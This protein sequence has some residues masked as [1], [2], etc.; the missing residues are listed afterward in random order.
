MRCPVAIQ[1]ALRSY[2]TLTSHTHFAQ[3]QPKANGFPRSIVS[4]WAQTLLVCRMWLRMRAHALV[5]M[6][7]EVERRG[8]RRLFTASVFCAALLFRLTFVHRRSGG[9]QRTKARTPWSSAHSIFLHQY[10]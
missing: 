10:L 2:P 5:G 8:K 1:S 6:R 3:R 4:P 9:K 7:R